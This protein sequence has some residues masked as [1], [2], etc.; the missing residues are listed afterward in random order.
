M[1][2]LN[3]D[4][5]KK[6][7]LVFNCHEA[8]VYQLAILGYQLDIIVGLKGQ[9]KQIWDQQM[10][11]LPPN[12]RLITLKDA[13]LSKTT[14]HCI[15]THNVADLLDIKQRTEPRIIVIHSTIEGRILEE[16]TTVDPEKMRRILKEYVQLIGC[17]VVAVS[18]LKGNS[19]DFTEDIV[20]FSADTDCYPAYSGNNPCGLR[21][22]NFIENRS[23]I[24]LWD[25]HREAFE[26]LPVKLVGHNPGIE[27]VT[28]AENWQHL[29]NMLSTCRFYIHTAHTELE[30]GYNMA[31][32]EAMAAGM[33]IIGNNHPSSPIKHGVSGFLSDDP[34]KLKKY[35][36]RLLDDRELAFRMGQEARKTVTEEFSPEIFKKRFLNSIEIART[37]SN[38]RSVP[39]EN[40][41]LV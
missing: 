5:G 12:S 2:K 30:D 41:C 38:M 28:A 16:K 34:S 24:L 22:C 35:A 17:H 31:T 36:Q 26:G 7:L 32:L 29:K 1:L 40:T 14:Y 27:S 3:E 23:K 18:R 4:R 39:L 25:L 33:P 6:T 10:R 21:I 11:P 15:I 13:L 8:W 37:K 20:P 19:W 9:Y